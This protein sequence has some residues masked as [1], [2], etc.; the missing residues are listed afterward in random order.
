MAQDTIV[1]DAA[2][3]ETRNEV[4]ARLCAHEAEIRGFGA[5]ALYMFGS[6]ARGQLQADSDVDLFVEY[7]RDG[8]FDFVKLCRLEEFLSALLSRAVDLGTRDG[9]HPILRDEIERSS[10][11]VF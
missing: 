3:A 2:S 8:S 11:K 7:R 6:A 9:L 10:V 4:L 1:R 5:T